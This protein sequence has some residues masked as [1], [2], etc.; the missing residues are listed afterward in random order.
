MNS[1]HLRLTDR[2][3]KMLDEIADAFAS[4]GD[5]SGFSPDGSRNRNALLR[6]IIER[7]HKAVVTANNDKKR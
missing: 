2:H 5:L 4:N 3:K 1:I 6:R 7:T